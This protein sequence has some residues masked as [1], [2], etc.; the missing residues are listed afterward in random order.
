M[1]HLSRYTGC[2]QGAPAALWAGCGPHPRQ[3]QGQGPL[4]RAVG[5]TGHRW[6]RRPGCGAAPPQG[7][8]V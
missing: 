4:V 6:D 7:S 2:R 5:E 3:L 8:G 1:P